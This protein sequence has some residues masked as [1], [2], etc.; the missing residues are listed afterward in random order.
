LFLRR[1]LS[2]GTRRVYALTLTRLGARLGPNT[3]LAEIQPQRLA[4]ALS[5]AYPAA[6]PASWNRHVA[7]TRSFAAF[8]ARQGWIAD[9][10]TGPLE[11]RREPEDRS[12]SLSFDDLDRLWTRRDVDVREKA[13]W[14]LLYE[15]AARADEVLRLNVEDVDLQAKRAYVRR[16]GGDGDVLHFQTGSARL[17]PKIIKGRT[18]GPLF[19]SHQRSHGSR[20]VAN[21]DI[22]PYT[23][24]CRLSYRRAAEMFKEAAG[25]AGL[26]QLRHS[27]LTHLAEAGVPTPL[28]MAKSGHKSL[29]TLQR[30]AR[31]GVDAVARLTAEHDPARR[32][33]R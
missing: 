33:G 16:K 22:D 20:A 8:A 6:A 30:Y 11:R 14:R 13:L 12:K 10:W 32:Q 27:A 29:R 31:P 17:L 24:Q 19:L 21:V 2:P 15:T 1:D 7:T 4:Q 5:E 23:E 26:H 28:L 3:R 18:R 25:G 9:G